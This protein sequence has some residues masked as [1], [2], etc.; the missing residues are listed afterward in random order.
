MPTIEERKTASIFLSSYLDTLGF[1]NG[2]WEFNFNIPE[3]TNY[4]AAEVINNRITT[5]FFSKGGFSNI[6]ISK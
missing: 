5:Q 6:N 1:N 2:N 3:I 4:N